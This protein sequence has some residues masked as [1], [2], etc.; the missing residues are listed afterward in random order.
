LDFS[1]AVFT[2]VAKALFISDASRRSWDRVLELARAIRAQAAIGE[3]LTFLLT[4]GGRRH[5]V[6]RRSSTIH[7]RRVTRG[8]IRARV[9]PRTCLA[10]SCRRSNQI[11]VRGLS[12]AA[13]GGSSLHARHTTS[14]ARS[15]WRARFSKGGSLSVSRFDI[16]RRIGAAAGAGASGGDVSA[17]RLSGADSTG[18]WHIVRQDK[19]SNKSQNYHNGAHHGVL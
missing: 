19:R 2:A 4:S 9:A 5:E 17:I 3:L 14:K 13:S 8:A 15:W 10:S 12:L 18:L 11:A 16:H 7:N 1:R 6:N